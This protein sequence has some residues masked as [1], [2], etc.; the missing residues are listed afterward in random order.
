[1]KSRAIPT[2]VSKF[3][4]WLSCHAKEP[5]AREAIVMTFINHLFEDDLYMAR[6]YISNSL[7]ASFD[8]IILELSDRI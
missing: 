7:H 2:F 3:D 8:D 1:M 6:D 4:H 5:G